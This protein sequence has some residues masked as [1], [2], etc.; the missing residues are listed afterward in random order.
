MRAKQV[1]VRALE[2]RQKVVTRTI[3]LYL[4]MQHMYSYFSPKP[5]FPFTQIFN[6]SMIHLYS[7][8]DIPVWLDSIPSP[9]WPRFAWPTH[10][11]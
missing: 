11:V 6:L 5:S 3:H 10:H 1:K 2:N 7:M 4:Y 8:L 9:V